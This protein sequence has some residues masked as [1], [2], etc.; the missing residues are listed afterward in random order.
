MDRKDYYAAAVELY[1]FQ[2]IFFSSKCHEFSVRLDLNLP[3]KPIVGEFIEIVLNLPFDHEAYRSHD[4]ILLSGP[5]VA[6]VDHISI[7]AQPWTKNSENVE[8]LTALFLKSNLSLAPGCAN[9]KHS[10]QA[11]EALLQGLNA[12]WKHKK[13][14]SCLFN[15]NARD[16]MRRRMWTNF[17]QMWFE[18][19]NQNEDAKVWKNP[20][21]TEKG[22]SDYNDA[23][24]IWQQHR[25]K[26]P[27]VPSPPPSRY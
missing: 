16:L 5:V 9:I 25:L 17:H 10:Q 18:A 13:S 4:E 21:L 2:P 8:M 19:I 14:S 3:C 26:N 20:E 15:I 12:E 11:Y 23:D 22:L 7:Q 1:V 6:R 27:E 24:Q